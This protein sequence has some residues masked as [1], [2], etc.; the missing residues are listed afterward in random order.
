MLHQVERRTGTL[1]SEIL[2][3]GGYPKH[4]AV[5]EAAALGAKM[6][7]P[8]PKSRDPK[9]D[10]FASKPDDSPP[11]AEWRARMATDEAKEVY[12][13]RAAVAETVNADAKCKRGLDHLPRRGLD[14]AHTV[15]CLFALTYNVLRFLALTTS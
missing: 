2:V 13:L 1:P 3:D 14:Q 7:A 15:A 11:V 4:D 10:P 9:I 6:L 8:L 5:D 12:K